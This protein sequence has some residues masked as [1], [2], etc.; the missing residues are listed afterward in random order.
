MIILKRFTPLHTVFVHT[1]N[2]IFAT[3][4]R[5]PNSDF[6]KREDWTDDEKLLAATSI[7]SYHALCEKQ[8]LPATGMQSYTIDERIPSNPVRETSL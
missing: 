1:G 8:P 4:Y 6:V 7:A 2:R 3:M 5:M